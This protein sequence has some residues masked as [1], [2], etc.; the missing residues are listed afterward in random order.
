[1]PQD[2]QKNKIN[3]S[4][5]GWG[6]IKGHQSP[7]PPEVARSGERVLIAIFIKK[8][9]TSPDRD[10]RPPGF[11]SHQQPKERNVMST[12]LRRGTPKI[13]QAA[14]NCKPGAHRTF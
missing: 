3:C 10:G 9:V 8:Q 1:M 11:C 12:Q 5:E 14:A 2:S 13:S 4:L 6:R 7:G